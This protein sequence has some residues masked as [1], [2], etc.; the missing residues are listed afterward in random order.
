MRSRRHYAVAADPGRSDRVEHPTLVAGRNLAGIRPGNATDALRT[1]GSPVEIGDAR[2]THHELARGGLIVAGLRA[3]A[4]GR[5][6]SARDVRAVRAAGVDWTQPPLGELWNTPY[7]EQRA[8]YA[9]AQARPPEERD[10]DSD[11]LFLKG[12]ITGASRDGVTFRT[13]DDVDVLVVAAHDA[14]VLRYVDN[15]QVGH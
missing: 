5:L 8:A 12:C 1:A 4:D 3:T 9:A 6:S 15:L 2:P 13:V 11:L 14:P 7:A 10:P